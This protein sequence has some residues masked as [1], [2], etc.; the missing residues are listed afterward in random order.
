[1][2]I[3]V[4]KEEVIDLLDVKKGLLYIDCTFGEGGHTKEILKRGGIVL[5][6]DRDSMTNQYANL[7]KKAFP[8]TFF[9]VNDSFSNIYDI[10]LK[11]FAPVKV[12]GILFDLGFSSNQIE[13]TNR[14]FSFLYD[15]NLDMR[16]NINENSMKAAD[17]INTASVQDLSN[18]FFQYGEESKSK[19]VAKLIVEARKKKKIETCFELINVIKPAFSSYGSKHFAT[20]IFQALR[21]HI[22]KEL[23][24]IEIGI[25]DSLKILRYYGKMLVITFHSLED[26]I[27]KQIFDNKCIIKPKKDEILNNRRARSATLRYYINRG[28][29]V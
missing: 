21:I 1:M 7:I 14:G 8:E 28:E 6:I 22:N 18:I 26:G 17:F 24:H 27:V 19:I 4:M 20:K 5:A 9:W 11:N 29:N 12:D 23:D 3:S 15:S 2:H 16:Y 25:N 10:W 13:D